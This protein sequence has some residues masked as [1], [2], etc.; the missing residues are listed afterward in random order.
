[1]NG[2]S[3]SVVIP[4]YNAASYLASAIESA[5]DQTRAP[6]QVLVVDDG[7]TDDTGPIA[8]RYA[9]N[10]SYL[11][12]RNQG[13]SVA[14]N[15]G[16]DPRL[17]FRRNPAVGYRPEIT[18]LP[19]G[20]ILTGAT[21]VISADRRF[22]RFTPGLISFNTIGDVQTFNFVSG[23]TGNGNGG[24][25]GGTGGIGGGA[26]GFGGGFGGFGGGF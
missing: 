2:L 17:V 18:S 15:R 26:G 6:S 22:V 8:K 20:T 10:V 24:L 1:V 7:S 14:R 4:A 9:P 5:L 13:V 12:Q 21:A 19:E 11:A 25:T 23:N 3:V 16:I